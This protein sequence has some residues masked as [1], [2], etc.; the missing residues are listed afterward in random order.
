M[1]C[2]CAVVTKFST[3]E[4]VICTYACV[5]VCAEESKEFWAVQF[6]RTQQSRC[7]LHFQVHASGTCIC[8]DIIS[9]LATKRRL[10]YT[11]MSSDANQPILRK[12][13][14]GALPTTFYFPCKHD[15]GGRSNKKGKA[16]D[17]RL[18]RDHDL[19]FVYMLFS[20]SV[21]SND[22]VCNIQQCAST[23]CVLLSIGIQIEWRWASIQ[24][25]N[26]KI[27]RVEV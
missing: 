27:R 16:G 4:V 7:C 18:V 8:S 2:I 21:F 15:V 10:I 22:Y 14:K 11:I 9:P 19:H 13:C 5:R 26:R 24:P 6:S 23:V 12:S 25:W 3:S 1:S 17:G 20:L